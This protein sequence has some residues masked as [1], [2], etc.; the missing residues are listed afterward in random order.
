MGK[1]TFLIFLLVLTVSIIG[2]AT[3]SWWHKTE[4]TYFENT[5]KCYSIYFG[6]TQLRKCFTNQIDDK[7]QTVCTLDPIPNGNSYR[8]AGVVTAIFG[9]FATVAIACSLMLLFFGWWGIITEVYETQAEKWYFGLSI[10]AA[11][12]LSTSAL[13]YVIISTAEANKDKLEIGYSFFLGTFFWNC[14]F[15]YHYCR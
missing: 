3:L 11:I 6:L 15:N 9:S 10:S 2:F 7:K 8:R 5:K 14:N 1:L 4:C 12:L 13:L